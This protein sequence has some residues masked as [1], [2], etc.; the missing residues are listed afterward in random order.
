MT[1]KLLRLFENQTPAASS[2]SISASLF[3]YT[4]LYGA[5][6]VLVTVLGAVTVYR[7]EMSCNRVYMADDEVTAANER[8]RRRGDDGNDS[9]SD[10][11]EESAEEL[12]EGAG[13]YCSG[14][15][16]MPVVLKLCASIFY[17]SL[18]VGNRN[19]AS[20]MI[21]THPSHSHVE[22]TDYI[23]RDL[24]AD[25]QVHLLSYLHPRDVV[26]FACTSRASLSVVDQGETSKA[27]WKSLWKRDYLWTVTDFAPGI[28]AFCR[29]KPAEQA[30][31]KSFYFLFG[32][33]FINYILAGQNTFENCLVGLHG[34]IYDITGFV[35]SHPG[36]PETLMIQSGKDATKFFE[37]M[38]HSSGARRLAQSLCVVVNSSC[39][40]GGCGLQPTSQTRIAGTPQDVPSTVDAPTVPMGARST[41]SRRGGTLEAV[42]K[43]FLKQEQVKMQ[44]AE[45]K[46][47]SNQDVLSHVNVYYDPFL[48]E[49]KGWYTNSLFETVYID[50]I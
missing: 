27:L 8:R 7:K 21:A 34:H 22:S 24:P 32:Q 4:R 19:M 3:Y 30:I 16:L 26:N 11:W 44:Q 43:G 35:H 42:R 25:V 12:L 17:E 45:F 29:S 38:N 5:Q 36:S 13:A 40:Q 31:D 49:W 1:I 37:D 39:L 47:A 33:S 14:E 48:R 9:I 18:T 2:W 6:L 41:E 28:E 23:T 15:P 46:Y 10:Q 20:S 50:K